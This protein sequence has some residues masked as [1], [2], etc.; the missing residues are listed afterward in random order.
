MRDFI[1]LYPILKQQYHNNRRLFSFLYIAF[2]WN[3]NFKLCL[4]S[5][6]QQ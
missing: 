6:T 2:Y 3:N 1:D 4:A 5:Q